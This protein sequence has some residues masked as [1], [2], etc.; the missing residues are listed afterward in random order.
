M[1]T[2]PEVNVSKF[3]SRHL[4]Q[5]KIITRVLEHELDA[6]KGGREVAIDRSLLESVLDT[7]DIFVD[8]CD[9]VSG[10]QRE[11]QRA[12]GE[13]KPTVARLN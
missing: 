3:V 5:L 1:E 11:R 4:S 13:Q 6:A 8:D 9:N 12:M 7:V 2:K 10:G